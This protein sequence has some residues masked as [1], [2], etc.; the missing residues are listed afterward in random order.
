MI[1]TSFWFDFDS[2]IITD[3]LM[4]IVFYLP[5]EYDQDYVNWLKDQ[6]SIL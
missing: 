2:L 6:H 3:F 1:F 5:D 4:P